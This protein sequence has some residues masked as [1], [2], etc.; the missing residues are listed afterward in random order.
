V[1]EIPARE[2]VDDIKYTPGA[3]LWRA[4]RD[5]LTRSGMGRL[6]GT[7]LYQNMTMRSSNTVLKLAA[8]MEEP[9]AG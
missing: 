3:I 8:M 1:D 4:D 7:D 9:A 2:G 6:V 5:K